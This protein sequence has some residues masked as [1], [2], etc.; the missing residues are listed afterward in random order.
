MSRVAQP[1]LGGKFEQFSAHRRPLKD[2][3]IIK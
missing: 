3:E 2:K 1:D